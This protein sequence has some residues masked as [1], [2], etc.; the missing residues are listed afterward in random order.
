MS[1]VIPLPPPQP[2]SYD[3]ARVRPLRAPVVRV[4][5]LCEQHYQ[6]WQRYKRAHVYHRQGWQPIKHES[7]EEAERLWV[8]FRAHVLQC[9]VVA[10]SLGERTRLD[11]VEAWN[12][13]TRD[14][15]Q[16]RQYR[17]WTQQGEA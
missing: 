5:P 12:R 4:C 10:H 1:E 17:A 13:R 8:L 16:A 7:L 9:R 15:D 14:L 11:D 6:A 2:L 3:A